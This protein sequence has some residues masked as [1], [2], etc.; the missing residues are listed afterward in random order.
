MP[1]RVLV[2]GGASGIGAGTAE[3]LDATG[4]DV[5][6]ADV[7]EGDGIVPL[8][9]TR[10]QAWD[11]VVRDHG[12]FD[13]LVCSAGVRSRHPLVDLTV[14]EWD[15]VL[16]VNLT[17]TFLGVQAFGRAC[18]DSGRSGA[19]VGIGSIRGTLPGTGRAHYA[20]SKAAVEMLVRAAAL[21]L[22]RHDVRVNAVAPGA[23]RTPMA[24]ARMSELAS[25]EELVSRIPQRRIGAPQDVAAAV[26]HLLSPAASYV[27]GVVLPVDGGYLL[28][29]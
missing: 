7:T 23:I 15:R 9:V 27:T 16:R 12:P 11:A 25:E 1:P 3:H 21:E 2:T 10:P 29:P 18:R 26:A 13:A 8:D 28:G 6:R 14:Q 22:A 19:V 20:S 4:W 24:A 17:G 5:I